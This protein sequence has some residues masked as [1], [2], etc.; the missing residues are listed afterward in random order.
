MRTRRRSIAYLV[1]T[2]AAAVSGACSDPSGPTRPSVQSLAVDSGAGP[3]FRSLDLTLNQ[4]TAVEVDYWAEGTPRLRVRA[5]SAALAHRIFLPRLR[6]LTAYDYEIRGAAAAT[7]PL[8]SGTFTTGA[9]PAELAAIRFEATGTPT[10]PITILSMVGTLGAHHFFSGAVAVDASGSVV[11]YRELAPPLA[12]TGLL[13]RANGHYAMNEVD[14]ATNTRA[15]ITEFRPDLTVV[16]RLVG[17]G[18]VIPHHDLIETPQG[19]ILFLSQEVGVSDGETVVGE[20]V[21]EWH[22][23]GTVTR[24]WSAFDFL[25]Y[26]TDRAPR[27]VASDWLHANSVRLGPR[28]NVVLSFQATNQAISIAP[29]YQALEW[30]IGG[31]NAT[32]TIE[33]DAVFEGQHTVQEIA[34]DR[35]LMFDNG[36]DRRGGSRALELAI[37]PVTRHVRRVWAFRAPSGNFAPIVG[38]AW[39]YDNGNTLVTFGTS[40]TPL[41]GPLGGT[42]PSEVYESTPAGAVAWHLRVTH[43]R[44]ILIQ[45]ATP[46]PD[47][48]GEVVV[49][50]PTAGAR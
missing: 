13:R 50:P 25:R 35:L 4:A 8:A 3:I 10:H 48:G 16:R 23:D 24:R 27:G 5:D 37:D 38:S 2:F 39:R 22:E 20:A 26:A 15:G 17:S 9:L 7:A 31:A 43:E 45:R 6:A 1:A 21:H 47:V 11:W 42:G 36:I 32:H 34:P 14:V 46:V 29:G 30:R 28:G 18:T 12:P 49:A 33:P 40:G 19:T 44:L 41:L